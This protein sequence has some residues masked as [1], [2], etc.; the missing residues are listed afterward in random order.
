M[1]QICG[2]SI[3]S[4][5]YMIFQKS[6]NSGI[7]P[8]KWKKGN[9]VIVHKK[10]SKQIVT[11]YRPI[12]LLPIVGKIFEKVIYNNLFN[13]FNNNNFLSNN[14]SGFELAISVY[15]ANCYNT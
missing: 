14:Q 10:A 3:V 7:F 2:D 11:N 12:S 4:P 9:I 13:Y 8:D 15:P 5:L 6:L 1:I